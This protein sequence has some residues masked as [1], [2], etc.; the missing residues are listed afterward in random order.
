MQEQKVAQVVKFREKVSPNTRNIWAAASPLTGNVIDVSFTFSEGSA[1]LLLAD[2]SV[3][4]SK[5]VPREGFIALD[6]VTRTFPARHPIYEGEYMF[7]TFW[8]RDNVL[9]HLIEI[10]ATVEGVG[11]A[12]LVTPWKVKEEYIPGIGIGHEDFSKPV[13]RTV[14]PKIYPKEQ[15]R[16]WG[17]SEAT[18]PAGGTVT[19][20]YWNTVTVPPAQPGVAAGVPNW[21]W[22]IRDSIAGADADTLFKMRTGVFKFIAGTIWITGEVRHQGYGG[23][24]C[25]L[26]DGL[27]VLW[28]EVTPYGFWA[29][30]VNVDTT[31]PH[32][33]RHWINGTAI[34]VI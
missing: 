30:I 22:V 8:N 24:D 4:A 29:E 18:I 34:R 17:W 3:G 2:F 16:V 19:F 13:M 10:E 15:E 1:G 27:R 33:I 32:G 23:V 21:E 25:R 12:G 14:V 26:T 11:R 20:L 7:V 9:P 31:A 28:D 5:I 6:G